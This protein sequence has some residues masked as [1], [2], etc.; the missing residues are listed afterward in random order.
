M[1]ICRYEVDRRAEDNLS[2]KFYVPQRQG[3]LFAALY[4]L[5]NSFVV[6]SIECTYTLSPE[7]L[8]FLLKLSS[9]RPERLTS[10][11]LHGTRCDFDAQATECLAE[12]LRQASNLSRVSLAR[13][14]ASGAPA[15]EVLGALSACTSLT[16]A[17]NVG[18]L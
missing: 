7:A 18:F 1:Q 11:R 9:H 2:V 3:S 13:V 16:C 4:L 14:W 10:L 17:A 12:A 8:A 5:M 6:K 15:K